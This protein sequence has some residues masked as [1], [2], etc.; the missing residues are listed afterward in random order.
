LSFT[1]IVHFSMSVSS[2]CFTRMIS[3]RIIFLCSSLNS[4]SVAA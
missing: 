2:S 4:S 3:L 1:H